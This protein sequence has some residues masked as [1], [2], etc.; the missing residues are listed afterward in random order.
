MEVLA[1]SH[2]TLSVEVCQALGN[3]SRVGSFQCPSH[4]VATHFAEWRLYRRKSSERTP[5]AELVPGGLVTFEV[6]DIVPADCR[7]MEVLNLEGDGALL[8]GEVR[9]A[10]HEIHRGRSQGCDTPSG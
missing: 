2:P 7:L 4:G 3:A 10:I 9:C 6:G 8:T 1:D 5:R